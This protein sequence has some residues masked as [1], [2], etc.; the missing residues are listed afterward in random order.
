[1]EIAERETSMR[2]LDVIISP[3]SSGD[4]ALAIFLTGAALAVLVCGAT[5]AVL[6][7]HFCKEEKKRERRR[8]KR[9]IKTTDEE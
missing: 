6:T 8:E 7:L 9:S 1:M 3:F 2:L 4:W 5:A